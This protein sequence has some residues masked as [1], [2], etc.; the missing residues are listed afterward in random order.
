V[1]FPVAP[2]GTTLGTDAYPLGQAGNTLAST[3]YIPAI[4]SGKLIEKFYASTVLGAISNTDYEGEIKNKGDTVKIRTKPTI[5]IN[6]YDAD[7]ALALSRP[8]GNVLDLLINKGKY[9]NTILDDVMEVQSDINLLNVWADDAAEQ[10][11]IKI[12]TDVLLNVLLGGAATANK[13]ATAGAISG[14]LNLGV[15]SSGPLSV[16]ARSPA[17][18]DVEVLDVLLRL[19]QALDEQ[20]IPETGRW[21]VLPTWMATLI[22]QSELREAYLSGDG[23]SMLRNGRI[24]M[25]D[26]FTLYT[27]NL[28]PAGTGAGLVAG[29]YAVFAGHAHGLTF[30]SQMTKMET[31]RSEQ[32][33]GTIM[34]G[35]QVYGAKVIDGTA[36]AQAI[37]TAG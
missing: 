10:M 5:T 7:L 9:F 3:G 29:E 37:V 28:L 6:D 12:D 26:R 19:G 16:V 22:K 23:T 2:T 18:G 35:L 32:T 31:L 13:G 36:I 4:W 20:N 25:V 34:R 15:T 21:V 24:G 17:S 8:A 33:F 11:K 27:S 30:A 1:A 14:A